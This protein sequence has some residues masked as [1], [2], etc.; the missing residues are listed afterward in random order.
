MD[1]LTRAADRVVQVAALFLAAIYLISGILYLCLSYWN[2]TEQD[3]WRIYYVCLNYSWLESTLLK[4]NNHS[5]I[6]PNLIWLADLRFFHGSQLA[7]FIVGL[8]LLL[9][10]TSLLLVPVWRDRHIDFTG[11]CLATL[12]L[13]FGSFWMGRAMITASG[14]FN[15]MTSLVML[16]AAIAFLLLPRMGRDFPPNWRST[17]LI[18]LAGFLASFSFGTGLALWPTLLFLG[19]YLRLPWRSLGILV[20]AALVV[21][22]IYRLLPPPDKNLVLRAGPDTPGLISIDTF[23][24]LCMLVGS[25]L[26]YAV[27][28]LQKTPISPL[29]IQS[30]GWLLWGGAAGLV[31]AALIT[32]PRLLRRDLEPKSVEFIG[33]ALIVLDL[34]ALV[35]TSAG[36]VQHFQA[37]PFEAAAPR[38][39]F[40]SSL[41][42]TGILLV[43]IHHAHCRHWLRWP[44]CLV[45]LAFPLAAW[46]EHR[47]EGF[48]W[49]FARYQADESATSVI[50][51][52]T[53]PTRHL[54]SD[55]EFVDLLLPQLRAR[56][57]DMFAEG[58][59]DLIGQPVAQLFGGRRNEHNFRGQAALQR[60]VG[61]RDQGSAV[62]VTGQLNADNGRSPSKMVIH[63]SAG[64]VAGVARSFSTD[65][66]LN[67]LLYGGRMPNGQLAGY[68]R[69]YEAGSQYFI[70]S[71]GP[72]GI[73]MQQIAVAPLPR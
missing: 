26:F 8:A 1:R 68:I 57:L 72:D 73:S 29:L 61:G 14:G 62:K 19:W 13:I 46:P 54:A 25:P 37:L 53:D 22:V 58:L 35:L 3:F 45:V 30:S 69:N 2:V 49:R 24:H 64:T 27:S 48:R 42:W 31:L 50:N 38:Y 71:V 12:V 34:C 6:F 40:W 67:W 65:K 66:F 59:Q 44:C 16:G 60:L 70:R 33:L 28:A 32:L 36:R 4:V 56:R 18:V 5:V 41:F 51:G 17:T 20:L 52:V 43:A 7:L 11:K 63:D 15:C 55:Q 9:I 47:N 21:V 39:I 10:T 23:R